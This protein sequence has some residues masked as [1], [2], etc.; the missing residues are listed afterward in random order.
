MLPA[1]LLVAL[2]ADP[3]PAWPQANGPFGNFNPRRYKVALVDDLKDARKLWTSETNLLGR[4]KGSS[5]G[6]TS[7]F[8]DPTT[9]HG[10]S[11]SGLIV[12]DGM[13]F[14]SSFRPRGDVWP[15]KDPRLSRDVKKYTGEKLARIKRQTALDADDLTVAIDLKTGKTVWTA[16]EEDK[17][18]NRAAGKRLQ[19]HG[20]PVYF[21]GKVFSLGT[22]GRVYC[23]DAKTGKKLWEDADGSLVKPAEALKA[24]LLKER[25][26]LPGGQG[27]GASPVVAGGVLVVPEFGNAGQDAGLRGVD[28]EKGKTLWRVPAATSRFATPGVWTHDG[29]QYLVVATIKGELRLIEPKVGKVL[30]TVTG[31][32]PVYYP[33][34]PSEKHVFVNV[35]SAHANPKKAKSKQSWGRLAAYRLSPTK[36]ELAWAVPDKAPFWFE[37]HMD[38]C[39]MRRVLARDGRVYYYTQGHTIDPAKSAFFFHILK[40]DSGEVLYSSKPG[41]FGHSTL[42]N[43]DNSIIGQAWLVEDRL[44]NIPDAAHSDR[45]TL[46]WVSVGPK[47]VK[48]LGSRWKPPHKNTTA[49]EVFIEL[50]YVGGLFLMRNWQGQVVCYDLRKK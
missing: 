44:L 10:G 23:Y 49:Y 2:G 4:A 35:K 14:A 6:F 12:A 18:L 25:N 36:A 33:L 19:F 26:G 45:S 8:A 42:E 50:P 43:K 38:I 17:G 40:E 47:D 32:E 24:K 31:L 11:S 9:P 22:T 3:A 41:E 27:M 37:N 30:W 48:R 5:S 7:H 39:A 34:S 20:T 21:A 1:L 16:I 15:E 13:V 46:Q 28:V 29:K